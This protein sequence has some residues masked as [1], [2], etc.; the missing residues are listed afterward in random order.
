MQIDIQA[1]G[2]KLTDGLREHTKRRLQFALSWAVYDVR[3]VIVRLS[4]INGPRGGNDKRCY[5][6]IPVH[7]R[8]DVVI[9][10]VESDLYVAID[11]AVDRIERSVARRL[12]RN[13]EHM[14]SSFKRV[15]SVDEGLE[16]MSS[17]SKGQYLS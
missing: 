8:P 5:I 11:R 13:R 14:H 9:D 4:D 16:N 7:G 2:F 12:E 1:R 10:D 17:N 3:K 6:Q 15:A